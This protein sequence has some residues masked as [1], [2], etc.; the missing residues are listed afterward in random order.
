MQLAPHTS[1][2]ITPSRLTPRSS[3]ALLGSLLLAVTGIVLLASPARAERENEGRG[4]QLVAPPHSKAY[5]KSLTEWLS[6]FWRWQLTGSNPAESVVDGV[7]LLPL[8]A[9]DLISGA[10]TPEDPAL[11]R[12]HVELTL[13]S[14]TPFVLP[15]AAWTVERYLDGSDDPSFSADV[16]LSAVS[17]RLTI[18]GRLVMS[19]ANEAAFYVPPTPLDP[20]VVYPAPTSYGSVATIAFQSIG[21]VGRPLPVG[22]HTIHLYEPYI[23]PGYFGTIFDN[24]WTITVK[25][26]KHH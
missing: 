2:Q 20:I 10:G 11:Y 22:V 17:P 15:E 14:E 23:L 12:G 4:R 18:D 13:D 6:I 9:G 25:K 8:P 19:D 1:S 24:T 5:G 21:I 16:F 26:A 7:Q 3:R